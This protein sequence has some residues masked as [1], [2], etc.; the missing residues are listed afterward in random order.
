VSKGGGV[1]AITGKR[2][3]VVSDLDGTMVGDDNAT[4]EFRY[5]S[6]SQM[7][8]VG[9]PCRP[10]LLSCPLCPRCYCSDLNDRLL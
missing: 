10:R 7:T 8:R 5:I 9:P 4:K 2:V 6:C 1:S 3:M